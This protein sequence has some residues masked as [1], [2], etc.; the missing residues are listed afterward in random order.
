VTAA[1]LLFAVAISAFATSNIVFI[2]ELGIGTALAVLIDASIVRALPRTVAH[3]AAR[4]CQLVG[5]E[6]A[7]EGL[8]TLRWRERTSPLPAPSN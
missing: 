7:P 5:R 3:G 4:L 1:A 2:K 6:T 8:P